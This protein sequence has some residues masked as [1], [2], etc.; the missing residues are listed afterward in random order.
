MKWRWLFAVGFLFVALGTT[1]LAVL[2]SGTAEEDAARAREALSAAMTMHHTRFLED[3]RRLSSIAMLQPAR[4]ADAGELL[5][6]KIPFPIAPHR[7]PPV[8]E[9]ALRAAL[10]KGSPNRWPSEAALALDV[11]RIDTR[12][13]AELERYAQWD[14]FEAPPLSTSR[15]LALE[16]M[17]VPSMTEATRWAKVR[18]LQGLQTDLEA[19]GRDVEHLARL[20]MTM[21]L[22]IGLHA[23]VSCL[24]LA[25][26]T[27]EHASREGIDVGSWAPLD[28][29]TVEALHRVTVAYRAYASPAADPERADA[30]FFAPDAFV[31]RCAA[32]QE[33]ATFFVAVKSMSGSL[34]VEPRARIGR[35]LE[36]NRGLCRLSALG[37]AWEN[38]AQRALVTGVNAVCDPE[39]AGLVDCVLISI[40]GNVPGIRDLQVQA[41]FLTDESGAFARYLRPH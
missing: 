17:P 37:D 35:L 15:P 16:M 40:F 19:A 5:R 34:F 41:F 11:S 8:F 10:D 26:Q 29:E 23:A 27:F 38:P 4:G 6:E 20:L 18:L 7:Y 21:E 22:R 14:I 1:G 9:P 33:M 12:W 30:V 2:A 28:L 3:E 39:R 24:R 31:G 13:M 25:R 32:L 36:A